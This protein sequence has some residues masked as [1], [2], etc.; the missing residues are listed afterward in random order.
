MRLP[1]PAAVGGGEFRQ[2]WCL[3]F[4]AILFNERVPKN[5]FVIFNNCVFAALR[6]VRGRRKAELDMTLNG[7]RKYCRNCHSL[8]LR[9][10]HLRFIDY[11]FAAAPFAGMC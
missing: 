6:E 7:N 4:G 5:H 9:C 2:C 10:N 8:P 1:P 3:N 11:H